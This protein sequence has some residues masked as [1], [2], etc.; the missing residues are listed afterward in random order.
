MTQI[1]LRPRL[2]WD[3]LASELSEIG[4]VLGLIVVVSIVAVRLLGINIRDVIERVAR[5]IGSGN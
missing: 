2:L 3:R 5:A 1:A 4:I